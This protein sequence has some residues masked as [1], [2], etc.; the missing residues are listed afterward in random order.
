MPVFT[1]SAGGIT[2]TITIPDNG[3][4][5]EE[6]APVAAQAFQQYLD[7]LGTSSQPTATPT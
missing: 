7:T 5:R 1:A 6:L 2:K 4:S 3:Q